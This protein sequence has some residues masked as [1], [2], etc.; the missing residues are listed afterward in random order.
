M[1][2]NVQV[3]GLLA[4][5]LAKL[6]ERIEQ[7][8]IKVETQNEDLVLPSVLQEESANKKHGDLK[9]SGIH[10]YMGRVTMECLC[11]RAHSL[12]AQAGCSL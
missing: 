7:W 4:N 2:K 8:A 3:D 11:A 1:G 9:H 5:T 10:W 12:P 6:K